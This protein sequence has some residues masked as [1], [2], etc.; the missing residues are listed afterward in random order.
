MKKPEGLAPF[1]L[2]RC[3]GIFSPALRK[4][5]SGQ[6]AQMASVLASHEAAL[7][8]FEAKKA[9]VLDVPYS[10]RCMGTPA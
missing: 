2:R 9:G 7:A 10:A 3:D 4:W 5:E 8:A 1:R 6:L